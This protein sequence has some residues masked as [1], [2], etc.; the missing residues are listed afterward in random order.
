MAN[1]K[2]AIE[3]NLSP[4]QEYLSR[5]GY[6]CVT[7]NGTMTNVQGIDAIVISGADKNV[8]G[9]QDVAVNCPVINAEGMTPEQ[10][11]NRL[12]QY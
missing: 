11:A 6:N 5:Q 10:V 7:L 12:Q 1:K 9:I 8:M 4:I 2:V 3:P